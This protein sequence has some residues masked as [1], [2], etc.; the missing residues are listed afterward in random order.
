MRAEATTRD[1][2]TA[3]PAKEQGMAAVVAAPHTD[4]ALPATDQPIHT[5]SP[6]APTVAE[7][8]NRVDLSALSE[9]IARQIQAS[10]VSGNGEIATAEENSAPSDRRRSYRCPVSGPRSKA[11]LKLGKQRFEA[12]VVDE[13]AAGV[14]LLVD[15]DIACELGQTGL[16]KIASSWSEVRVMNVRHEASATDG[17]AENGTLRTRLGLL[18]VKDV[19]EPED[20]VEL[21]KNVTWAEVKSLLEPFVPV[22]KPAM[23]LV[24]FLTIVLVVAVTLDWVLDNPETITDPTN[25][26]LHGKGPGL[27]DLTPP[28]ADEPVI[29]A[30]PPLAPADHERPR[31]AKRKAPRAPGPPPQP[32]TSEPAE[33]ARAVERPSA[34][35]PAARPASSP[36]PSMLLHPRTAERLSL[37]SEQLDRFHE[38]IDDVGEAVDHALRTRLA[39]VSHSQ[40]VTKA[41]HA[42][43]RI[44]EMLTAEQREAA[45]KL[46]G[47]RNTPPSQPTPAE[48]AETDGVN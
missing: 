14:S 30:P 10:L 44:I 47:E 4:V 35:E 28:D 9:A 26:A 34:P 33:P 27:A 40:P 32:Q 17:P 8:S 36:R 19:E 38:M 25:A 37:S 2:Q 24:G 15:S 42:A 46:L 3:P 31:P 18:R 13:S 22:M 12:N 43:D 48:P 11:I 6:D 1:P 20:E 23:G 39:A 16:M 7:P 21:N 5:A 41:E 29:D 45:S